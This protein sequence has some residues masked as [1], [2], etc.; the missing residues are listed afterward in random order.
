MTK[1]S[2]EELKRQISEAQEQVP[3]GS[4]WRHYKGGEYTINNIA[5]LEE[6]QEL[7][8]I[9]TSLAYPDVSFVRPITVWSEQV[10]WE[11]QTVQRFS[12]FD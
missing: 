2:Y 11:G 10:E 7:T 1:L 9:Y 8:V 12:R 5:V 6:T 3:L 4:K